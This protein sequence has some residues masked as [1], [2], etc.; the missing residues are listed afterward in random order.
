MYHKKISIIGAGNVGASLC[1]ELALRKMCESIV[2]VDLYK[3]IAQAKV[4]DIS[5]ACAISGSDCDILASDDFKDVTNS[6]IVVMTAGSPRKNGMSRDELLLINAK[7]TKN[8]AQNIAKYAPNSIIIQVANPLD[9]MSYVAL[10]SSGFDSK[11]VIGMAGIL[12]TGR[13]KYFIS[14]KLH[15]SADKIQTCIIGGHGDDMVALISRTTV[16]DKLLS[17]LLNEKQIQNIINST[18]N[19]GAQIVSYLKTSA[20]YAPALG[21]VKIIKAL[22]SPQK[23]TLAC[24][25]YLQGEYGYSDVFSGV[26]VVLDKNG[27]HKIEQ[28]NLIDKEKEAFKISVQNVQNLI[29]VLKE[30]SY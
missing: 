13:M 28:I 15:V 26:L 18:K 16:N 14:K 25:V 27:V 8:I 30:N 17:S 7:I 20:Y 22:N 1:Y 29:H 19:G 23:T 10:K 3:N 21:V 2:L 12:D 5:Q 24:S 9:A 6:N 4:L 11:K